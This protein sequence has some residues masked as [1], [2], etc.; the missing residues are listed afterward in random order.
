MISTPEAVLKHV[1]RVREPVWMPWAQPPVQSAYASQAQAARFLEQPQ[2]RG[3]ELG[4]ALDEPPLCFLYCHA[5]LSGEIG[6]LD[7]V[8]PARA[9]AQ[10]RAAAPHEQAHRRNHCAGSVPQVE[11]SQRFHY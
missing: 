6:P 2:N 4:P 11:S 10:S 3:P 1:A 5:L 8:C 9:E 7:Y